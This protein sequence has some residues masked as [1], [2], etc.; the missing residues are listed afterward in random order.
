[1]IELFPAICCDEILRCGVWT[2]VVMNHYNTPAKHATSLNLDRA[3][4]F[5][6]CVTTDTCVDCGALRQEVHKQN[7]F[8]VR[9]QCAHDLPS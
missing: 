3:S 7:T 8:S 5:L 9:K 4:Q 6:K 2:G 1:M